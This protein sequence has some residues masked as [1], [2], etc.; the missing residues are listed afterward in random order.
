MRCVVAVYKPSSGGTYKI[1]QMLL[2]RARKV[3]VTCSDDTQV[4]ISSSC[5]SFL[6]QVALLHP[7]HELVMESIV[8]LL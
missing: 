4:R 5:R 2:N 3:R 7:F 6:T 1:S 8:Q